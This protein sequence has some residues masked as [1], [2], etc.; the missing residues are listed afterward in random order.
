MAKREVLEHG[1]TDTEL[2]V[3]T[4]NFITNIA[5]YNSTS[6]RPILFELVLCLRKV[7]ME[8]GLELHV[9]HI[10]G[11]RIMAQSTNRLSWEAFWKA[12]YKDA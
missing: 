5:F 4:G 8:G 7:E 3:F 6:S 11:T 9:L 1:V 12:S 2:F 10:T